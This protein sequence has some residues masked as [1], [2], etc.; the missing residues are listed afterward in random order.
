MPAIC[1]VR[2]AI[3]CG[4]D[5]VDF[6]DFFCGVPSTG[7]AINAVAAKPLIKPKC[8]MSYFPPFLIILY[9]AA[10]K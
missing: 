10:P 3:R 6:A 1:L 2:G 4:C 7:D 8:F 5:C 9:S